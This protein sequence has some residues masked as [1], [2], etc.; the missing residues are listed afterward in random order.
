MKTM[1]LVWQIVNLLLAA[2]MVLGEWL[3]R[4]SRE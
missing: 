4:R 1:F 3:V 2:W